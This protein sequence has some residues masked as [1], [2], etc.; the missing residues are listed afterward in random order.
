M[1]N[2]KLKSE[3]L[4]LEKFALFNIK[5]STKKQTYFFNIFIGF[6]SER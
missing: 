5:E 6:I 4:G 3:L 2:T 1:N